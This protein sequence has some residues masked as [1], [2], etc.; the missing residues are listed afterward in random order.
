MRS[1]IRDL[2]LCPISQHKVYS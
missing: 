1:L 2:L